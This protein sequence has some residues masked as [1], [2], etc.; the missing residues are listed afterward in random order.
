MNYTITFR[1]K[2]T[3]EFLQS[4]LWYKERSLQAANNFSKEVNNTLDNIL[5]DP[6]SGR[7][8]YKNFFEVRTQKF[9]F[10]IVYFIDEKENNIIITSTFHF[11]RNPRNKFK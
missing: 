6:F 9:P 1:K 10:I 3:S 8:T 5:N 11:K 7:N 2:A 4:L